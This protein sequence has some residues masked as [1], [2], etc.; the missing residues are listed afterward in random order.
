MIVSEGLLTSALATLV[1]RICRSRAFASLLAR[2]GAEMII[3]SAIVASHII[4]RFTWCAMTASDAVFT[5]SPC[6]I[7]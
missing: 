1:W 7:Q 6:S 5:G 3:A 4:G 2:D